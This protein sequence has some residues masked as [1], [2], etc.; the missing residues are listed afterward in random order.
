M[1]QICMDPFASVL[2]KLG[3]DVDR[4][5]RFSLPCLEYEGDVALPIP[6]EL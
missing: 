4:T 2:L 6:S 3:P 1:A 5:V